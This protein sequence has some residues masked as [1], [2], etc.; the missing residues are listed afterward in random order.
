MIDAS[1]G[2]V[3]TVRRESCADGPFRSPGMHQN[4]K[5]HPKIMSTFSS[6]HIIHG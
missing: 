2:L 4:S 5:S 3:G 1:S 6:L